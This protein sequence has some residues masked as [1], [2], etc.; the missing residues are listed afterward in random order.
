M[1]N[2]N[3][4][5]CSNYLKEISMIEKTCGKFYIVNIWDPTLSVIVMKFDF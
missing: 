2:Y 4:H 1:K 3:E 5:N